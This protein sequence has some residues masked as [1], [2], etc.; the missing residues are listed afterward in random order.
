MIIGVL[1]IDDV[2]GYELMIPGQIFG[3]ANIA[4]AES[5]HPDWSGTERQTPLFDVRVCGER[6]SITTATDFGVVKIRPPFRLDA[7]H[8]ADLIIVPGTSNFLEH[9]PPRTL[10]VLTDIASR[11]V[12]VASF[13]VGAFTLA[14]A[15]LLDERRATTH[16]QF[17]GELARRYPRI[18]V[19]PRVLFID[20]GP[21][22][23]AAGVS[24]GIDLCLYIIR[25]HCGPELASRTAR[26]VVVSAWRDGGQAQYM[27]NPGP[28]ANTQHPLQ[29]TLDWMR[30]NSAVNLDLPTIADHA[31]MSVR[32]L[33][34]HFREYFGTT[35]MGMLTTIRIDQARRLLETTALPM[36][37]IA[38]QAGFG[39]YA[40]L[41]YHF[42]RSVGVSLQKYRQTYALTH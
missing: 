17:A 1:A 27:E 38:A 29:H 28:A 14:A 40:S 42:L 7:L 24:S 2:V 4:A 8:D 19:D 21:V 5:G 41:R 11:G 33:N 6:S 37:Q 15:G 20:D 31:A 22:L 12:R 30:E 36:E 39:S 9:P 18:D 3:M 35:P 13:C 34:R 26:R 25:E 23:T 10:S 16:W 32:S